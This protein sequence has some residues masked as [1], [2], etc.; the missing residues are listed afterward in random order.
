MI[1]KIILYLLTTMNKRNNIKKNE[2]NERNISPKFQQKRKEDI[3]Q[4]AEKI[5]KVLESHK[6]PW[7][8]KL[9][10]FNLV[11][12]FS[13]EESPEEEK[14]INYLLESCLLNNLAKQRMKEFK[15]ITAETFSKVH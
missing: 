8:K 2:F 6:S 7:E 9:A 10:L 14:R 3:I 13:V 11:K 1:C 5:E 12:N 4:I 15:K